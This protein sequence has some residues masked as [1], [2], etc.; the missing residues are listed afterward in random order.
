MTEFA[1]GIDIG[2]TF[3]DVVALDLRSGRYET[4]KGLTTP[5]NPQIGATNGGDQILKKNGD[6]TLCLFFNHTLLTQLCV[7]FLLNYPDVGLAVEL[8]QVS[9]ASPFFVTLNCN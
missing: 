9:N 2:G 7:L 3:T 5:E 1:L 8:Y 6:G 4:A